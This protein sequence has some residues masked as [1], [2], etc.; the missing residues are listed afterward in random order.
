MG[1]LNSTPPDSNESVSPSPS[2]AELPWTPC[3]FHQFSPQISLSSLSPS[4]LLLLPPCQS[5]G[6]HRQPAP[7]SVQVQRHQPRPL[8]LTPTTVHMLRASA[9]SC[10]SACC[11]PD[12]HFQPPLPSAYPWQN[13][14][15]L[16]MQPHSSLWVLISPYLQSLACTA[17]PTC[18]EPLQLC[19]CTALAQACPL[20]RAS[21]KSLQPPAC[22][23][24][25]RAP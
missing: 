1:N 19:P 6:L 9:S 4:L 24:T 15:A 5:L 10:A 16:R 21:C 25:T 12:S 23:P 2:P 17:G 11:Q 8:W 14:A 13:P 22:T 3:R 7:A 20:P 18:N